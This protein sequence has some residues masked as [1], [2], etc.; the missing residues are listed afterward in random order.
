[1]HDLRR[2]LVGAEL[3]QRAGDG[4]DRALHVALDEQ[5]EVLAA[6]L[7]QRLHHLLERARRAGRAHRVATLA[8]AIVG[9]LARTALALDDGELVA[10]LGREVEA[11]D[12]DR[13]GRAGL[14]DVC[15]ELVDEGAHA[16]PCL[17]GDDDVAD[18]QRAALHEHGADRT[19]A[20]LELG[21][22]DDAFGGAVGAGLQVEEF[23]LQMDGFQQ[24]V[25]VG[26]L[27]GRHRHL[28][29]LARHALDDDLVLQQL[30][31]H[32]VR[33]RR[34]LS[35]LLMATMIGTPA[36]LAWL[37]ASIVCGMTPSS[38]ATTSTTM[39]VTLAPRARMA[40]NASWPGVSMKVT[41]SPSGVV[42]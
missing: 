21:L 36:A 35:I 42:T 40:V 6:G 30:G 8:H 18:A 3:A 5:R 15:A 22:D 7:L 16:S 20:A 4:F 11:Q 27:Q 41:F 26:A 38:A 31:A 37:M 17:A 23:G 39:S 9:D 14:R 19:A 33:I 10:G 2:D 29:R 24:L 34:G 25:E 32:A 13:D 28:E 1:M 12:L